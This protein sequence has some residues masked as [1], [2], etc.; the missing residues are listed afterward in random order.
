MNRLRALLI[1]SGWSAA[2]ATLLGLLAGCSGAGATAGG[3]RPRVLRYAHAPSGEEMQDTSLRTELLKRYLEQ[4]LHMPVEMVEVSFYGPT[5][6]A[7]RAEKVDVA[8]FGPFGYIIAAQKAGAQAI[9]VPGDAQRHPSTYKSIIA[10]PQ[11]SPLHSVTDLKSHA[12]D[13]VFLFT[14]PASTS[15]NLIPRTYLESQGMDPER[16]FKKVVYA[17]QQAMAALTVKSRKVDA[18]AMMDSIL[19]RL[20]STGKLAPNELRVIWTSDPI[21]ASPICVRGNLPQGFKDEIR[22]ALLAIPQK[23]PVLWESMKKLYRRP[24]IVTFVPIDDSAYDQLREFARHARG[25][26]LSEA[27]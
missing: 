26:N 5:I 6:E 4:E 14:D 13:L 7:M 2:L 8:T 21:P 27:N 20:Q 17:G 16:D 12:R 9:V 10:V 18:G 23:Q 24:N 25:I 22:R 1:A 3:G 19:G 15:G 11:D